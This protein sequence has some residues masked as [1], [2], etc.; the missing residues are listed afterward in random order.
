MSEIAELASRIMGLVRDQL[1]QHGQDV[2]DWL[3]SKDGQD[4]MTGLE[5]NLVDGLAKRNMQEKK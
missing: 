1:S 3:G 2:S 4:T 5:Q